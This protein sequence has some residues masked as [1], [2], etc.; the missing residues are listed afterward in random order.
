M[1]EL[2]EQAGV[3]GLR[4]DH[5]GRSAGGRRHGAVPDAC[6]GEFGNPASASHGYR[7]CRCGAGRERRA[8]RWPPASAPQ[9]QEVVWTSGATEANNLAIFGVAELLPRVRAGTSS[10]SRTEHKAVLDPCRELE[11]RGW[12]VTYLAPDGGGL[13]ILRRSPRRCGRIPCWCPSCTSTTRSASFRT[14]PAIARDL[15]AARRR[16]AARGCGAERGQVRGRFCR[17]RRR[18]DVAV[19]A[20]GLRPEGGR[21]AAGIA[22]ARRGRRALACSCAALQFGGGQER[23]LRAGT[24]PRIRWWAWGW[25]LSWPRPRGE[26]ESA[27]LAALQERLWRGLAGARRRL[28][29]RRGR[30]RRCRTCSTCRSRASRGKACSPRCAGASRSRQA[31]PAPRRSQE[32]SYVLRAL[33]RGEVLEREQPALRPGPLHRRAGHRHGDRRRDASGV[34]PAADQR[35][36]KYSELTRRYFESTPG[37]GRA[38]AAPTHSAAPPAAADTAPGCSSTCRSAAGTIQAARFLAFGCPHTIAVAAWVAEQAIGRP[39][40]TALPETV[41]GLER[42]LC[43]AGRKTRPA[44]DH[45]RC[46]G[47]S[48]RSRS[49]RPGGAALSLASG[50]WRPHIGA[51]EQRRHEVML[52]KRALVP[53]ARG[54]AACYV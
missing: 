5:A 32:P 24:V 12:R 51:A 42:A 52:K 49:G 8:R 9:P 15:C 43:G 10:P 1:S 47:S 37:A 31:P 20:Q 53:C 27:R 7:R 45:R 14:S 2:R 21:R 19:G 25:R 26:S 3:S 50:D 33:G 54:V 46:L 6:E 44:A 11:R 34:A 35:L 13:I 17:L 48:R 28:A 40:R 18:S 39:V 23:G 38:R 16:A 41:A 36:M 30:A 29:Q 22:A 4:G